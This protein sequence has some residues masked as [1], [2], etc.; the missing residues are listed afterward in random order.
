[1][2][3]I[4]A[5]GEAWIRLT[6]GRHWDD[7]LV[8]SPDGKTIY[9]VSSRSGVYN[10][11]GIRFDSTKGRPI[12][13]A[14]RVTALESPGLMIPDEIPLAEISLTQDKLVLTMKDRSGSICVLDHVDR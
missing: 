6:D 4:P 10:V 5:F 3:V 9:F 8:G 13:D 7:K 12:G 14:F 1:M 11:W 2:A